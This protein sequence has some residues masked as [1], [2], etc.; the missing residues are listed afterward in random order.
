MSYIFNALGIFKRYLQQSSHKK[1]FGKI[2]SFLLISVSLTY[3]IANAPNFSHTN[4]LVFAKI[5]NVCLTNLDCVF[6]FFLSRL[7]F[8]KIRESQNSRVREETGISMSDRGFPFDNGHRTT[9]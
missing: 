2:R 7:S 6:A 8:R 1:G 5:E 9:K 3:S 4:F